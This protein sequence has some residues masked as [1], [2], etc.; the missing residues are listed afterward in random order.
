MDDP[1][2]GAGGGVVEWIRRSTLPTIPTRFDLYPLAEEGRRQLLVETDYVRE[3]AAG[4]RTKPTISPNP[5]SM[6]SMSC[7]GS[8]TADE[9]IVKATLASS[10]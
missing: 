5:A 7:S 6:Q 4:R 2:D 3:E 10:R 1:D 8:E 9:S